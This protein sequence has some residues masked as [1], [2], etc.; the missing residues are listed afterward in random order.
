MPSTLI[1]FLQAKYDAIVS[2]ALNSVANLSALSYGDIV[3]GIVSAID[4]LFGTDGNAGLIDQEIPFVG[5]SLNELIGL[6]GVRQLIVD[7]KSSGAQS[8]DAVE[9]ALTKALAPFN[10]TVSVEF[11]PITEAGQ[12]G[13]TKMK[14]AISITGMQLDESVRVDVTGDDLEAALSVDLGP[15]SFEGGAEA[16]VQANANFAFDLAFGIDPDTPVGEVPNFELYVGDGSGFALNVTDFSL[17]PSGSTTIDLGFAEGTVSLGA[18]AKIGV[19]A[20]TMTI[21]NIDETQLRRP[22]WQ[23]SL[24]KRWFRERACSASSHIAKIPLV[25]MVP[26]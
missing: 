23:N 10:A 7:L 24:V 12:S 3:G 21:E 5:K 2:S 17:T 14:A 6:D 26:C 20:G 9:A 16:R 19:D 22:H 15:L 1:N 11:T 13:P 18:A 8:L 25:T 4:V